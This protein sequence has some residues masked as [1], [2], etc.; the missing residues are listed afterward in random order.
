MARLVLAGSD[1]QR[2]LMLTFSRRAA[3]EMERR[4]GRVLHEALGFGA[5]ARPP[6]FPWAGTIHAIGAR[7][8]R[9][10]A[11]RIGLPDTFTILDRPDSEDLMALARQE[12]GLAATRNRFPLKGTCL[13]IYCLL[14]T[15]PSPRDRQKSRMPSS[16]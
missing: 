5:T 1:P 4:V 2:I 3:A 8:L 15:S 6:A 16:A 7:L 14:Y 10:H 9:Q 11:G 13:S 12:L